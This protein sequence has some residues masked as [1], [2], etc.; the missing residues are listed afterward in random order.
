MSARLNLNEKPLISWKG[1][2]FN[3]IS[4]S[5]KKN[6]SIST[7]NGAT[8]GTIFLPNPLK[9]YRKE[10]A[11]P[12]DADRC[13]VRTSVKINDFEIPNGTIT[14][15]SGLTNN[16]LVNTI[17]TVLPNNTC[18]E[19]GTCLAFLSP[20]ENA[21]RRIRSSGM[22]QKKYDSMNNPKYYTNNNQYL[23]SRKMTQQQNRF[24]YATD[25]SNGC[26]YYKPNNSQFAQQG[27][28]TASSL[29]SRVR[30]D[31]IN[32]SAAT[33]R[34]SYGKSTTNALAYGVP[35]NGY[36]VKD[37]VGYPVPTYP[38]FSKYSHAM[39]TCTTTSIRG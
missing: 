7:S 29:T 18:E 39:S 15:S 9:I 38:S 10:I 25:V 4:A 2:T 20:S 6:A 33:M 35:E 8:T 3:Q 22:I 1:K 14:N 37:K 21:K 26:V 17:D 12:F 31:T 19:P 11:S 23:V 16:G 30:Y 13:N 36:T 32:S 5:I 34:T 27:A 24:H 28:V